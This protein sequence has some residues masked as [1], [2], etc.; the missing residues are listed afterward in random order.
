MH[1]AGT[2]FG[3]DHFLCQ[4]FPRS[5]APEDNHRYHKYKAKVLCV[6]PVYMDAECLPT[7]KPQPSPAIEIQEL[8]LA[9]KQQMQ[10]RLCRLGNCQGKQVYKNPHSGYYLMHVGLLLQLITACL[11]GVESPPLLPVPAPPSKPCFHI[12]SLPTC[13]TGLSSM[14]FLAFESLRQSIP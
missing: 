4:V 14:Q 5:I 11:T 2:M 13:S 1:T 12:V 8:H 9:S 3:T 7:Q 10:K 6:T